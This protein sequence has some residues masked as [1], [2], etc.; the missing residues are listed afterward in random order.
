MSDAVSRV[1]AEVESKNSDTTGSRYAGAIRAFEAWCDDRDTDPFEATP[2]TVEDYLQYQADDGGQGDDG[3]AYQTLTVHR[4]ALVQFYKRARRLAEYGEAPE[5]RYDDNP[6]GEVSMGDIDVATTDTK[7]NDVFE[8][9]P[10]DD[11]A[12]LSP[13]DVEELANNVPAPKVRNELL[14]RLMYQGMLRRGEAAR[15][16]VE[17]VDRDAREVFI[18]AEDS[19]TG[20][21]HTAYYN[22]SLDRLMSLWCDADRPAVADDDNPYLFVSQKG[23]RLA[24]YTVSD[25]IRRAADNADLQETLYTNARGY[26]VSRV[27]GHTLRRAGATRLYDKSDDIYLVK[28]ALNHDSIETTRQYLRLEESDL[29]EKVRENW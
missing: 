8:N 29:G 4:A 16:K 15:I 28:E 18:P 13:D 25:I 5:L 19:K 2:L 23:G 9:R 22:D 6:A 24:D 12:T 21:S 1:I 10:D 3:Y 26:D 11:G 17:N 7:R 27:T 20:D 14:V